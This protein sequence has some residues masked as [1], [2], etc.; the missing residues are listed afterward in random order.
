MSHF[1]VACVECREREKRHARRLCASRKA[2]LESLFLVPY[3]FFASLFHSPH[4]SLAF[5]LTIGA[6]DNENDDD[7]DHTNMR[8][9]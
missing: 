7:D 2:R 9:T 1:R 5:F 3:A 6:G 4:P 8:L